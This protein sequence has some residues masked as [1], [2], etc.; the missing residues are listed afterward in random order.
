[1]PHHGSRHNNEASLYAYLFADDT[2]D[3]VSVVSANGSTHPHDEYFALVDK[4][5]LKPYCTSLAEQCKDHNVVRLSR[6]GQLPMAARPFIANYK[7]EGPSVTCQG[8]ITIE[9]DEAGVR[10]VRGSTGTP[11]PYRSV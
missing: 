9:I 3:R 10:R 4:F 8:D 5:G 11:C 1:M 2:K 6:A 7:S